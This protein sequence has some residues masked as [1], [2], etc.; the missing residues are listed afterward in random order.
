MSDFHKCTTCGEYDWLRSHVCPPRW[1][2]RL[3][4]H[5]DDNYVASVHAR[6]AELAAERYVEQWDAE[7]D[8]VCIDG[9]PVV[10]KVQRADGWDERWA[11]FVVEGEMVPEYSARR[12]E[13]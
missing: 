8:Y 5:H 9:D 7:G 2:V 6:T 12:M 1:W 13:T 10:V 11:T 3:P 4:E